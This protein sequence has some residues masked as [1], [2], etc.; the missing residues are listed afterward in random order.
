MEERGYAVVRCLGQGAQGRVYEVRDAVGRLRVVKQLPWLNETNRED[1]LREV[2]LL[3]ALRHPCIVPY[4]ENFLVRSS[5]SL[6]SE[7]L[8]CLVMSRCEH[9]L[10]V[11]CLRLHS[12][13]LSV[14]EPQALS[15]LVQLCW[16]LQHLHSRKFLHRDLKPQN[17]LLTQSRRVLLADFG[18]SCHLERTEDMR[19]TRVGTVA[20]MSPEMLEGK[21]YGRK[22]DQWALGCVLFE[23]MALEPPFR[24]AFVTDIGSSVA[25][26]LTRVPPGYSPQLCA[27]LSAL[28]A[29]RPDDR[30]SNAELLRGEL[31]RTPFHTFV[32]S[33][34]AAATVTSGPLE[35]ASPGRPLQA[36]VTIS[37]RDFLETLHSPRDVSPH[38]G[39]VMTV[40]DANTL[41]TPFGE[42]GLEDMSLKLE[43]GVWHHKACSD[44][45]AA[46]CASEI[47]KCLCDS[48][49]A[50]RSPAALASF[51]SDSSSN[52]EEHTFAIEAG[53]GASEWRQLLDEAEALLRPQPEASAL[54]EVEKLRRALRKLLGSEAE[55]DHALGFLRERQPLG[56]TEEADELM[57]QVEILD[58]LGDEG[59]HAMPLLERCLAL[60][61][62]M[63]GAAGGC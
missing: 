26:A 52:E 16:G 28:L 5:P 58:L 33:L 27:A 51:R 9:D 32:Q 14:V 6:P 7:D 31:L 19:R 50:N 47:E 44:T 60:E 39:P 1:A 38:S 57:L 23:I 4:L 30:P 25:K 63:R 37:M 49:V 42:N 8:L 12:E 10:R 48:P 17:V 35:G 34:E 29:C 53:L 43:G 54:D 61:A 22:T 59:L 18:V 24:S 15:W 55:V 20:F 46:S 2:R 21:P 3:S 45:D 56:E 62:T 36:G 40:T 11:E 13:G 41:H